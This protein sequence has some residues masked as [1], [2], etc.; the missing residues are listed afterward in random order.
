MG[1]TLNI[2]RRFDDLK[3]VEVRDS[4]GAH[5]VKKRRLSCK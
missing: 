3:S 4:L 2:A 1:D 5:S